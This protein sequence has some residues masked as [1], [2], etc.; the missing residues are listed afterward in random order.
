MKDVSL[1]NILSNFPRCSSHTWHLPIFYFPNGITLR[2]CTQR[3]NG[4]MKPTPLLEDNRFIKDSMWRL[5]IERGDLVHKLPS[6]G[7]GCGF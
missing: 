5:K 2:E 6:T 3:T 7:L 1:S 4:E